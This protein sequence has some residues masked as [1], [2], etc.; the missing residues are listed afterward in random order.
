MYLIFR[1]GGD[2]EAFVVI[3]CYGAECSHLM[4]TLDPMGYVVS[5]IRTHGATTR[6][7]F[8]SAAGRSL[9][10]GLKLIIGFGGSS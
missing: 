9:P 6:T 5:K 10:T 1:Y 8:G 3:I 7:W 4:M 2:F